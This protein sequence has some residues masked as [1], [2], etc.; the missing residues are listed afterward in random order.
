MKKL[1]IFALAVILLIGMAAPAYAVGKKSAE[2]VKKPTI[3]DGGGDALLD[4][5]EVEELLSEEKKAYFKEAFDSL[6]DMEAVLAGMSEEELQKLQELLGVEEL[7][8]ESLIVKYLYYFLPA[9]PSTCP[10]DVKLDFSQMT[11]LSLYVLVNGEWTLMENLT[12][13]QMK[14]L[15]IDITKL[16]FMQYV[17]GVWVL[18]ESVVGENGIV[19]VKGMVEGPVAIFTW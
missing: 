19:T 4:A 8:S 10:K 17:D 5:K 12:E 6:K 11:D 1:V 7:T 15:G 3:V 2:G 16:V 13:K 9:D 14:E 18:R